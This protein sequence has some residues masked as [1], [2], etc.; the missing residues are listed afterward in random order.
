MPPMPR[1]AAACCAA[2]ACAALGACTTVGPDYRRPDAPLPA[3]WR[4][5][6]ADAATVVDTAWWRAFGDE[7][8]DA[9][10]A[11]ALDGNKDLAIAAHR[12]EQ[13][14]ARLDVARADAQP[15]L[16]YAAERRRVERS[17]EQPAVLASGRRPDY[18][19]YSVGFDV[20]WEF[21]VWGRVARAGEAARAELL[22]REEARRAVMLKVVTELATGYVDLLA[23][24]RGLELARQAAA[25]RRDALVVV[26]A[27]REG[28]SATE[29]DVARARAELA[30]AEAALP[31]LERQVAVAENALSALAG[32][33]PGPLARGTLAALKLPPVPAGLPSDL[34][35]R[36]PDVLAAEQALVA[37]N[38]RIGVAKAQWF[39][40]ISLTGT[41]GLVSDQL[42]WLNSRD[43]RAGQ[44][45]LGLAGV[46][47]DGGR[48]AG[49]VRVAEAQQREMA[50]AW[51]QAVQG[52][53]RE[54]EDALVA[55]AKTGEQSVFEARRLAA[56]Q[57]LERL[58]RVRHEGGRA[59]RLELLD[60]ERGLLEAREREARVLREQH[61]A[62]VALYKAI[63]GGWMAALDAAR[64]DR[65]PTPAPDAA[66]AATAAPA[67]AIRTTALAGADEIPQ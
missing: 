18:N 56:L 42:R 45:G 27:K 59:N 62:H 17:E 24:D 44:L 49:D 10:I 52:A 53:L 48:I 15:R 7:R 11:A 16:G 39:P 65:P 55:R 26:E 34:L 46:L 32:A 54:T 12:I 1:R 61:A 14:A 40:T 20:A 25:N 3:Q 29:A 63:G 60:A 22:A 33:N 51:L 13:Y 64:Q 23:L 38:A 9:L 8:L 19:D 58:T 5:P 6:A 30:E 21:D 41:L 36:R 2:L 66:P 67:A 57:E 31:D 50:E 37:A 35:A 43:A 28:G 47:F 4:A